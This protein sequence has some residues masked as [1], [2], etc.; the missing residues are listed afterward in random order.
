MPQA[1]IWEENP[2]LK[3][4]LAV[5][6]AV[7]LSSGFGLASFA[8]WSNSYRQQIYRETQSALPKHL[9]SQSVNKQANGTNS[10]NLKTYT[11]EEY[12][13]LI[14]IPTVYSVHK[15]E[16]GSVPFLAFELPTQDPDWVNAHSDSA[17][18]ASVFNIVPY[19]Y[20]N[21]QN[22]VAVCKKSENQN[23]I[24]C[25]DAQIKKATLGK[26][27]KFYFMYTRADLV[28]DFPAD[29]T[30][31][32]FSQADE[33]IKTFKT[34]EFLDTSAWKTYKNDKYGFEF[35]YPSDWTE[36]LIS[37]DKHGLVIGCPKIDNSRLQCPLYFTFFHNQKQMFLPV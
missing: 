31:N 30:P 25:Q 15:V 36:P 32:V 34:I 10:N 18:E 37:D 35:K 1:K 8:Q 33:I 7:L 14:E 3:A 21:Y 9:E 4:L 24:G 13:F 19:T 17:S 28:G 20:A 5:L 6:T 2:K 11:N 16:N 29:F 23:N 12:G 27:N 22:M 26:N